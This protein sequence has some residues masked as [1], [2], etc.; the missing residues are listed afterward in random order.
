MN[1]TLS[2]KETS[3]M[4]GFSIMCIVLHNLLHLLHPLVKENEF[5]YNY[6]R[7]AYWMWDHI[8][9]LHHNVIGDILSFFGWYGVPIFIFLSGY[10]ITKKYES[11]KRTPEENSWWGF[12]SY[13]YSKLWFLMIPAFLLYVLFGTTIYDKSFE[14]DAILAQCTMTI[15]F[16]CS[17]KSIDPGVFWYFGLTLQLYLVYRL[18]LHKKSRMFFILIS[19][20]LIFVSVTWSAAILPHENLKQQPSF[21]YFSHNCIRWFLPF[22][23]GCCWAKIPENKTESKPL[24]WF[25]VLVFSIAVLIGCSFHQKLWLLTP[26]FAVFVI[27]SWVK[28]IQPFDWIMKAGCWLGA[29]SAYIFAIHPLIRMFFADSIIE[30][31]ELLMHADAWL[32]VMLYVVA[33]LAAAWVYHW[34]CERIINRYRKSVSFKKK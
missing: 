10:G 23:M 11:D 12:F 28:L 26:A 30:K 8:V 34:I 15:N 4:K 31:D 19:F 32:M 21:E 2:R 7:R 1:W 14:W 9:N 24:F 18:L 6:N 5:I 25:G 29:L 3:A 20:T 33:T 22:V 16:M 17:P 13:N 27:I